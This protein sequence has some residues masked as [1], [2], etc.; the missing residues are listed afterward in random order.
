MS[1]RGSTKKLSGM[2]FHDM[3]VSALEENEEAEAEAETEER[4]ETE[5]E[6]LMDA[7]GGASQ[8]SMPDQ[9][10]RLP[11][12]VGAVSK[13]LD[14]MTLLL[15]LR[16][17]VDAADKDG[18]TP[19]ILAARLDDRWMVEVILKFGA[20]T[21]IR[22]SDNETCYS[23]A[24]AH[25]KELILHWVQQQ[26]YT[27]NVV[28]PLPPCPLQQLYRV[29]VEAIPMLMHL[30]ELEEQVLQFFA[31]LSYEKPMRIIVPSEPIHGWPKGFCYADYS[32]KQHALDICKASKVD[33]IF[34]MRRRLNF[35]NQ[36]V[37][38]QY[39]DPTAEEAAKE[40][41]NEP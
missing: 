15:E 33:G 7:A 21:G 29:R 26:K 2:R 31:K 18:N 27:P 12:H 13:R 20:D 24:T 39:K 10:G 14:T 35:I 25:V 38:Y 40:E 37:H 17:N 23:Y 28:F 11:V 1:L 19:L 16:A 4:K 30:P 3:S 8:F 6:I 41:P 36:G 9:K 5:A 32:E 22:N 34:M